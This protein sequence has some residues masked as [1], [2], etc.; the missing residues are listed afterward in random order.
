MKKMLAL[1]LAALMLLSM[2]TGCGQTSEPEASAVENEKT[3]APVEEKVEEPAEDPAVVTWYIRQAAVPEDFD[4][5][6]ED[7]NAKLQEK[8]NVILDLQIIAPGE[9]NDKM[10]LAS[11]SGDTYE[12]AW[13]SNW[14]NNFDANMARGAFM[15]IDD[16]LAEY[17]QGILENCPEWLL[18]V[19]RVDGVQYAIPSLQLIAKTNA[20]YIQRSLAEEYGWTADHID[21]VEDLYPFLDWVKENYPDMVPLSPDGV[22]DYT[23]N[24]YESLGNNLYIDPADPSKIVSLVEAEP[25][26]LEMHRYWYEQGYIRQDITSIAASDTTADRSTG[27]YACLIS[28]GKPGGDVE[29]SNRYEGD[30][31]MC[32]LGTPKINTTSGQETMNAINVN[33]DEPEAAIKLLNVLWTDKEIFNELLFGLEGVHYVKDGENSVKIVQDSGY[34]LGGSGWYFANAC[35]TWVMP[36][37]SA[38][39]WEQT[40]E[41]NDTADVADNRGFIPDYTDY[42]TELAQVKATYDEYAQ[43]FYTCADLDEYLAERTEKLKAAGIDTLVAGIQAQLDEWRAANK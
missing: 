26:K 35:N 4:K 38:D 22:N 17:G 10:T 33:A 41:L 14:S 1:L 31:I 40:A 18:S 7:L 32:Y 13:T 20:V 9:F 3:E 6:M 36:S 39:I 5:V 23:D 29:Q 2:L 34:Y 8:I 15:P 43:G 21:S 19:G 42:Q 27:R 30:Y 28:S 11:T 25:A 24:P 12:I 16:L 37:Q